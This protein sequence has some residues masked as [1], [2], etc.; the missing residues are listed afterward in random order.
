M[1]KITITCPD[2]GKKITINILTIDTL[3]EEISRLKAQ[4]F[5]LEQEQNNNPFNSI[6]GSFNK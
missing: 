3:K 5:K 1:T 2:C 6:F 4:V